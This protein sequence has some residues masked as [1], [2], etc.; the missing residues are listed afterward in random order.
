MNQYNIDGIPINPKEQILFQCRKCAEC[1]RNIKDC[2]LVDS[3]DAYQ[4]ANWL[5]K[6][7]TAIQSIDDVLSRY[8]SP[9]PITADGYPIYV[10]QTKGMD[11]SCVFLENGFCKIYPVRP[12]TCRLY[13]ISVG[14]GSRGKDFEYFVCMD[15]HQSHFSDERIQIKDWLYQNFSR[16]YKDFLKQEYQ[17]VQQL[18]RLISHIPSDLLPQVLFLFLHYRYSNFNLDQPFLP[19]YE[20]N[21]TELVTQLKRLHQKMPEE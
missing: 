14:P 9:V 4:I 10:L 3:L 15:R 2:V 6:A 16:D 20:R 19:Q 13:P 8:C 18:G 5:R 1:C 17:A 12:W 7:D 21:H 11:D